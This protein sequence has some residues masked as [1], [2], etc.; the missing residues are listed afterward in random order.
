VAVSLALAILLGLRHA[1]DPDH[2][3]AVATLMVSEKEG[4]PARAGRLGLS[5]GLGHATTLFLFGLPVVLFGAAL[6]L[7]AHEI[8]E[9]AVG[10]IIVL[11]ALRLLYRWR[12]G[13]FHTH[14][15]QHDGKVHSH[16]HFHEPEPSDGHQSLAH[17]HR[18]ADSPAARAPIAAFGVGLVHGVGGSA[19]AGVLLIAA[20]TQR[21]EAITA[22][23]AFAGATALSMAVV[24]ATAGYLLARGRSLSGFVERVVPVLG[25]VSLAVGVWYSLAAFRIG[26]P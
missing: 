13:Y 19:G 17:E 23:I 26:G 22:L 6:P 25:L 14:P 2:L 18:H 10:A 11:L 12:L 15:H 1:T 3:T 16:P 9:L 4:G 7:L 24:S 21:V 20:I 5:W 8:A